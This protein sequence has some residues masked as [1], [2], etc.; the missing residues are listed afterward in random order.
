MT[1]YKPIYKCKLCDK[2][3]TTLSSEKY[4]SDLAQTSRHECQ[5]DGAIGFL[6]LV[7]YRAITEEEDYPVSD[8][9]GW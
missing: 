7:G 4:I 8:F 5:S 6:E 1:K 2:T 3:L 9:I